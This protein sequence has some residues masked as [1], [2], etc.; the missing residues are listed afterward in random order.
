MSRFNRT[1]TPLL[2]PVVAL[3][4]GIA[5][6]EQFLNGQPRSVYGLW[7]GGILLVSFG[8]ILLKRAL[9]Q[10]IVTLGVCCLAGIGLVEYHKTDINEALATRYHGE[11]FTYIGQ[12]DAPSTSSGRWTRNEATLFCYKTD[13]SAWIST[14]R[15]AEKIWFYLDSA[16]K[17][18]PEVGD[19]IEFRGRI[20]SSMENDSS[21]YNRYMLRT[22]GI[23]GRTYTWRFKTLESDSTAFS[24]R[25]SLLRKHLGEKLTGQSKESVRYS[26][27]ATNGIMQAL[28][29]GDQRAIDRELRRSYSRTGT[30]H[31]LSVSGLHVGIIF[32]ILNLL[33]GWIRL[34]RKGYIIQGLIVIGLLACYAVLTGLSPSVLRAVLMFS[35]F[36]IGLML[37]RYTNNLNTLC[38]AALILLLW[39]PYYLYHIGFQLSFAAMVGIIT[40]YQPIA[41]LWRPR[42]TV[43]RWLW[44]ITIVT[45]TAQF[46]VFPLVMY[47][48]GMVQLA[49][50]LL[51]P[52]VWFTV[53]AIIGGSLLYLASGWNWVLS[54]TQTV[55]GWQNGL[56]EWTASHP[57]IALEN[58]DLPLWG[59]LLMY[60][61]VITGIV[62]TNLAW[63]K[64]K[65]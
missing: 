32:V 8:L 41:G 12:I 53:P 29:L 59:C 24:A 60:I 61:P 28:A 2:E 58:I 22:K 5:I 37:S 45:V 57:W 40:L 26:D 56:I 51:N 65:D 33:L 10:R 19:I 18:R 17:I 25:V 42:W 46:G 44:S 13:S 9:W 4:A 27:P 35:L 36:Q 47:H 62:W 52:F 38:A 50:I 43:L 34:F 31:L 30:A 21:G 6:G 3:I 39:N 23:T 48:F 15:G 1:N 63:D 20:Y 64:K 14:H 55:A 7:I 49:G 16:Q 11:R 54:V